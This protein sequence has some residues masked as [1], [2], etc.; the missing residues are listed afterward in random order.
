MKI[1]RIKLLKISRGSA[2]VLILALSLTTLI[3][4]V[5]AQNESLPYKNPR[6]SLDERVKDLLG[7]M[8]LEESSRSAVN[9]PRL[10]PKRKC[11]TASASSPASASC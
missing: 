6:L 11:R 9:F 2:L 8:T 7:R 1:K 4:K 5:G 10:P 3:P